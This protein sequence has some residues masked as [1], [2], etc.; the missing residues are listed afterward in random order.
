MAYHNNATNSVYDYI[1][2]K[3]RDRE[4]KVG[5]RIAT[6]QEL[7]STLNVSRIAVRQAI[8]KLSMQSV[9]RKIQGSGTYVTECDPIVFI[10][11]PVF[12]LSPHDLLDIYQFRSGFDSVNVRFFIQN[13]SEQD[14]LDLETTHNKMMACDKNDEKMFKYDF[15]FHSIIADG[16]HNSLIAKINRLLS[17]N[18]I[19]Q[20]QQ[21]FD[22]VG[23]DIAL[24]YHPLIFK[25]IME[26]DIELASLLIHRHIDEA[27]DKI[28]EYFVKN[29]FVWK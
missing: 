14:F 2:N 15:Q 17:E 27:A 16:S 19:K 29:G 22:I 20:Q 28:G 3:I 26:K 24:Y 4:W 6:E 23:G 5:D 9:L 11:V 10:S 21:T 18:L 7:C 8:E 13:A 1:C 25:S 12:A